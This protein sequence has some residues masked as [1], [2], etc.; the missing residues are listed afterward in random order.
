[1][2]FLLSSFY[3]SFFAMAIRSF[4]YILSTGLK[5]ANGPLDHW[6]MLDGWFAFPSFRQQEYFFHTH[7]LSLFGHELPFCVSFLKEKKI[8]VVCLG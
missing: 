6:Y 8:P 2:N 7:T 3:A 4:Y 5:V 1:M